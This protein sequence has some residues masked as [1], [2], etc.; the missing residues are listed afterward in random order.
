[1]L[2]GLPQRFAQAK[3]PHSFRALRPSAKRPV[4]R[5]R[6][7]HESPGLWGSSD[8]AGRPC[9]SRTSGVVGAEQAGRP[10]TLFT[11]ALICMVAPGADQAA[12]G[13]P[14]C[15]T[16]APR[17]P[18]PPLQMLVNFIHVY[19][20]HQRDT[21]SCRCMTLAELTFDAPGPATNQSLS[22]VSCLNAAL[23]TST[24]AP[25]SQQCLPL[26]QPRGTQEG[27][28]R[29]MR[30]LVSAAHASLQGNGTLLACI[31]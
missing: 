15:G 20:V 3:L 19:H 11:N 13:L 16:C 4:P 5:Y 24:I 18:L 7:P 30:G 22:D 23:L 14:S 17:P 10:V 1:V 8:R 26:S 27:M 9:R 29:E 28:R 6:T 12:N 25:M 2:Q 21:L 31:S